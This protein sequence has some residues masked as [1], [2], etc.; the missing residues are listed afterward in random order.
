MSSD[1]SSLASSGSICSYL[2]VLVLGPAS[3]WPSICPT[4]LSTN[5]D[6]PLERTMDEPVS[7]IFW[8]V[9][10]DMLS[11]SPAS[12]AVIGL[13]DSIMHSSSFLR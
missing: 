4:M 7:R 1:A 3:V 9:C 2:V 12:P 10:S 11:A 6:A 8:V 5:T 13:V